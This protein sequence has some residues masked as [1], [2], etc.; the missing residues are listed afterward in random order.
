ML[1]TNISIVN[2]TLVI[3]DPKDQASTC[4]AWFRAIMSK[5]GW[6]FTWHH[7]GTQPDSDTCGFRV[8]M[9]AMQWCHTNELTGQLPRW[10]LTYCA[11]VLQLFADDTSSLRSTINTFQ[12]WA[13]EDALREY[14]EPVD[15]AITEA[16]PLPTVTNSDM[17]AA[18]HSHQYMA[19]SLSNSASG[20]SS[21]SNDPLPPHPSNRK[22]CGTSKGTT[23][24]TPQTT[25]PQTTPT[26]R[27]PKSRKTN[28]PPRTRTCEPPPYQSHRQPP[29]KSGQE[30]DQTSRKHS[31]K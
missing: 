11:S 25:P 5:M 31:S 3:H 17:E 23:G 16:E 24:A 8:V 6:S 21:T 19:S 28:M 29:P 10:F 26:R 13:Y 7:Y 15:W 18:S 30:A 4:G 14:D 20:P 22:K 2:K 9:L 12:D 1:V 27:I